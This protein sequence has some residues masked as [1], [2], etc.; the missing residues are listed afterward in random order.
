MVSAPDCFDVTMTDKQFPYRLTDLAGRLDISEKGS[1]FPKL[2]AKHGEVDLIISGYALEGGELLDMDVRIISPNMKLDNDL[3]SAMN[4]NMKNLWWTFKPEGTAAIDFR[5]FKK[6]GEDKMEKLDVSLI[7]VRALYLHFPYQLENLTGK[8]TMEKDQIRLIDIKSAHENPQGPYTITLN[9]RITEIEKPAPRFYIEISADDVPIDDRF[10]DALP[11]N[12]RRFYEKFTL[13]ARTDAE[14]KVFPNEVG[15]REVEY[16]G[17]VKISGASL[18]YE[19]IPLPLTDVDIEAILT[20]DLVRVEKFSAK[21]KDGVIEA[22]GKIWPINEVNKKLGLCLTLDARNLEISEELLR[23][24]PYEKIEIF[25]ELT[26]AGRINLDADINLNPKESDCPGLNIFVECLG[27]D[28][29]FNK[30]PYPFSDVKGTITVSENEI[31]LDNLKAEYPSEEKTSF[32]SLD[33]RVLLDDKKLKQAIFSVNAENVPLDDKF[34]QA[35]PDK[36]SAIYKKIAPG[37]F[38]SLSIPSGVITAG[39]ETANLKMGFTAGVNEGSLT[40]QK[41]I[42]NIDAVLA[43]KIEYEIGKGIVSLDNCRLESPRFDIAEKQVK[44]LRAEIL[45]DPE[46]QRIFSKDIFADFYGGPVSGGFTLDKKEMGYDYYLGAT[47]SGAEVGRM[48]EDEKKP[49]GIHSG[50]L[51]ADMTVSGYADQPNAR[52]GRVKIRVSDIT[53]ADESLPGRVVSAVKTRKPVKF[54]FTDIKIDSHIK[55]DRLVFD[56]LFMYNESLVLKGKG[57]YHLGKN[58][59]DV[60]FAAF[61]NEMTR[62][63]EMLE[64]LIR[65]LGPGIV[66]V[67]VRGKIDDPQI[68]TEK[69]PMIKSP[70]ELLGPKEE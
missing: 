14:I 35:L 25:D 58:S 64:S 33:S 54:R 1:Y 20:P 37:G 10:M 49:S 7:N 32:I 12:Q 9:G 41:T 55:N 44:G 65:G 62:E 48:F 27:N 3:M 34:I 19:E 63:P 52:T 29:T 43:G 18:E 6:P 5:T 45:F 36:A 47:V 21:N 68:K 26:A 8:L 17:N 70:F 57:N 30:F 31:I 61:G 4:E 11:A 53:F 16:I 24:L 40:K 67:D 39:K 28:I 59:L 22:G 66:K 15:T 60:T 56:D 69:L 38:V 42:D 51:K 50:L 2:S 46:K 13:A 23:S